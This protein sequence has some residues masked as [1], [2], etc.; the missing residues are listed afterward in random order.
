MYAKRCSVFLLE[1]DPCRAASIQQTLRGWPHIVC[2][3]ASIEEAKT[4]LS[5]ILPDIIL[6]NLNFPGLLA[7][8]FYKHLQ[9]VCPHAIRIVYSDQHNKSILLNQVASG[10]AHRHFTLPFDNTA[11]RQLERDTAVR[12]RIRIKKCWDFIQTGQG[13]PPLPPVVHELEAAL[14][15][16]NYSLD[17]IVSV[18]ERDPVICAKLLRIVNSAIFARSEPITSVH[19]AVNFLGVS[20][21]RKMVLF[22]S[23]IKH[24]QYP[25]K[26][27]GHALQV[28]EHSIQ[29]AKL[30][31]L[32]AETVAPG[33]EKAAA[34]AGLLHDIGKLVF[35][36]SL[37]E[38][39][40]NSHSFLTR[41][42]LFATEMEEQVF[43]ISHLELGSSLL[44]WWNLPMV[45]VD[46]AANHSHPLNSVEGVTQCVAIA[47][48]CLLKVGGGAR[49]TTDFNLLGK[50]LPLEKW[51]QFAKTLATDRI[52][53]RAA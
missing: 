46:A 39:L 47:D 24:F 22:I 41:Y 29:C 3:C 4:L 28:I 17:H 49:V 38:D 32:V 23:A 45:I 36:A 27:H 53:L 35:L 34:T 5:G 43:G 48:R 44:L 14:H 52:V 1:H 10:F 20:Q 9:T 21:I 37:E 6:C 18:L 19:R 31:A 16:P 13:L 33:Q 12:S 40:R 15:D 8:E 7:Q 26:F 2:H 51:L 42:G 25:K 11:C 30:A 50:D